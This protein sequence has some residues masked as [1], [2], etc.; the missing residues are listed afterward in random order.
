MHCHPVIHVRVEG[1]LSGIVIG[2]VVSVIHLCS[3]SYVCS[4]GTLV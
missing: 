2:Q 4:L 3:A 1:T